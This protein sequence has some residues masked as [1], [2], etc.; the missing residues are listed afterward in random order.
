MVSKIRLLALSM[1]GVLVFSLPAEAARLLRWRFNPAQNRLEFTTD[2]QIQPRAQLIFD[3]TRII[4][5]LPGTRLGRAMVKEA[6]GNGISSY[7][8]G[9]FDAQTTRIVVELEPGYTLDPRQVSVRGLSRTDWILELPRP[10]LNTAGS[11]GDAVSITTAPAQPTPVIQKPPVVAATPMVSA[12]TQVTEVRKTPDGLFVRTQGKVPKVKLRR[13]R[14][15]KTIEVEISEAALGGG[16]IPV[17]PAVPELGIQQ[18][19]LA[20]KS[21]KPPVVRLS[22]KVPEKAPDWRAAASNAGGIVLLP[23]SRPEPTQANAASQSQAVS[24][25]G[26]ATVPTLEG[27]VIDRGRNQLLMQVDQPVRYSARADGGEYV[28]TLSP[29]KLAV[30]AREPQIYV[31][32]RVRRVKLTQQGPQSVEVR[33]TPST[34]VSIDSVQILNLKLLALPLQRQ[35]AIAVTPPLGTQPPT[36]FPVFGSTPAIQALPGATDIDLPSLNRRAVIVIDPGHGGPDPGAVGN[37]LRETDIVLDVSRQVTAFLQQQG[38]EVVM[39]RNGEYDLDLQPRVDIAERA[40]ATAFVSIHA[41]AIS[42]ARPEV[43]GAE[44]YYYGGGGQELARQIH[45]SILQSVD[46]R[47]RGL[48]QARFYVIKRT[49]MPAALI[50]TGFITGAEDHRKL[51]DPVFRTRMARAIA[52]GILRYL[53]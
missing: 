2:G 30:G 18:V 4:V 10:Q 9:Q 16:A 21:E 43:N 53:Q 8:I 40:N 24:A 37:G 39:T 17:P 48:R 26:S 44:S 42:L 25:A 6:V 22:L 31:G 33:I 14:D 36:N 5:D 29:A 52:R 46:I 47:D 41:N 13:S 32:D 15:L 11:A 23:K 34:G 49:S 50:E 27:V 3:P 1:L 45:Q 51:A 19:I 7:R 38:V 12:P 35:G 20:Q 28:L